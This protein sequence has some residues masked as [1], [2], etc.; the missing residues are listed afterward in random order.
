M[1]TLPVIQGQYRQSYKVSISSHTQ[2]TGQQNGS[3]HNVNIEEQ[4]LSAMDTQVRVFL[5]MS[6]YFIYSSCL[7]L[8]RKDKWHR[9]TVLSKVCI[10]LVTLIPVS[11]LTLYIFF[12]LTF[13][14]FSI[15]YLTLSAPGNV[16][17]IPWESP[18]LQ[19]VYFI[20]VICGQNMLE[21]SILVITY[22]VNFTLLSFHSY[23][24]LHS[25]FIVIQHIS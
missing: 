16:V 18:P 15:C 17:C 4:G 10:A 8:A 21:K 20:I 1:S 14:V 7:Y 3:P 6:I 5:S 13:Y 2:P 24:A 12:Y 25:Y 9:T 11:K 22:V 19:I 23:S